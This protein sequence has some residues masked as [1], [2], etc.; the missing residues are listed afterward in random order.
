[1][2]Q[3]V[4]VGTGFKLHGFVMVC[5]CLSANDV[6]AVNISIEIATTGDGTIR[7]VPGSEYSSKAPYPASSLAC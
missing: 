4:L 5:P 7:G 1:M 3:T 6:A 2:K